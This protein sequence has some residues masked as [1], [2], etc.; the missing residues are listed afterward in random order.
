MMALARPITMTA[1]LLALYVGHAGAQAPERKAPEGPLDFRCDRMNLESKPNK[2]F[3]TG[4]IVARR[5][6]LLVCCD[7]FEASANDKW[8]WQQFV[9]VD[10][11]RALRG[12]ELMWSE[13]AHFNLDTGALTLTG[14]PRLRR[15]PN[16]LRGD[17]IVIDT[18]TDRAQVIRPR[19]ILDPDAEIPE[20]AAL[21]SGELP[22]KCPLPAREDP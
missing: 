12:D 9:C 7:R 13:R 5:D 14:N 10:R 6:T 8:D 18:R 16:L 21:P 4:N 17:R 1:L 22:A 11:V 19:G 3:C 20:A 15:G 2:G